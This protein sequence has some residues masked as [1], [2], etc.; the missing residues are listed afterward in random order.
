MGKEFNPDEF[1]ETTAPIAEAQSDIERRNK[2]REASGQPPL[3]GAEAQPNMNPSGPANVPVRPSFTEAPGDW[4]VNNVVAPGYGII[5]GAADVAAAH[6]VATSVA[7]DLVAAALPQTNIPILKQGQQ[8]A[9]APFRLA[10]GIMDTANAYTASRNAQALGQMEHQ[11]RQYVKAGQPVPQQLQSAVDA[12]RTKVTG[13]VAPSAPPVSA[14]PVSAPVAPAAE[15]AEQG[16]ANRIKQTAASRITNLVPSMGE[17]LG[18]AARVGSRVLGPAML[19]LESRDLGPAVPMVGRM[20][21][22]EINPM[23]GRP[24]TKQEI[25][26]YEQN[27]QAFDQAYLP[28]PQMRR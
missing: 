9:K 11:V 16:L 20:K 5:K 1:L 7:A 10:E 21:G 15:A 6:P 14:P 2:E 18:T 17:A 23:S 19:A 24:W 8:L 13:P 22:S 12:L 26:A 25:Q 28:Q 27:P 3:S 4:T